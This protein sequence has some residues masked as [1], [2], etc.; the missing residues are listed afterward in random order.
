MLSW[1]CIPDSKSSSN[2]PT[3]HLQRICPPNLSQKA[4]A[5]GTRALED[6][7]KRQKTRHTNQKYGMLTHTFMPHP[8]FLLGMGA[9]LKW[10]ALTPCRR[11]FSR[12]PVAFFSVYK[13]SLWWEALLQI[14]WH[15]N[16]FDTLISGLLAISGLISSD[17]SIGSQNLFSRSYRFCCWGSSRLSRDSAISRVILKALEI[18]LL[19]LMIKR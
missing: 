14:R 10:Q 5:S 19:G 6:G 3:T 9:M 1:L 11:Y 8:P 15:H 2:Y 12:D 18:V 7:K 13:Q 4:R 17:S 16:D